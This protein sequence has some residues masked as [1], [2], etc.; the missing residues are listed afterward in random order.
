MSGATPG[1]FAG[2]TV[3]ISAH[4]QRDR[5]CGRVKPQSR[6]H[7]HGLVIG[8]PVDELRCTTPT[9]NH[10][11]LNDGRCARLPRDLGPAPVCG[12][13]RLVGLAIEAADIGG[14]VI[15]VVGRWPGPGYRKA[16]SAS[17]PARISEN[18]SLLCV[19]S[20][21]AA[22]IRGV[23][24]NDVAALSSAATLPKRNRRIGDIHEIDVTVR[25]S[26]LVI[27]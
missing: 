1:R 15:D 16:R 2:D 18:P 24:K 27:S 21:D 11:D 20:R 22:G 9:R 7:R 6:A 23:G 14:A 13:T 5:P 26:L 4:R 12:M 8:R 19:A 25:I 17:P 10:C 3:E